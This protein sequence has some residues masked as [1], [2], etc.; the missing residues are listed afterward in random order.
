MIYCID[1]DGTIC[2]K[3][4]DSSYEHALPY[5]S[6]IDKINK[7]YDEGHHIKIFTARGGNTG[8][9]WTKLTAD[10]LRKLGVKY[11][12]LIM[13][14]PAADFYIDDKGI[15]PNDFLGLR[16]KILISEYWRLEV[17]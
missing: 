16:F 6:M 15:H 8:K 14:K 2:T 7:L 1:V 5:Q 10:Q 3:T 17:S 12:T 9:D 13:G 4:E 11:H